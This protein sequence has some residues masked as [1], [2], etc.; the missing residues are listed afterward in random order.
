MQNK[1]FQTD[2]K[3]FYREIGKTKLW[4]KKHYLRNSIEKFWKEIWGEE[5][6]CNIST[7]WIGNAEK[8]NE[9]VNEQK[10]ENITVLELKAALTKSQKWKSPG[11]NKV[12]K[13]KSLSWS[14]VAF[15]SLLNGIMQNPE[16]NFWMDVQRNSILVKNNDTKDPKTIDQSLVFQQLTNF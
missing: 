16:R 10:W 11:V 13:C 5:K 2:S 4:W 7:S 12:P 15:L 3:K 8:E 1:I 9:K 6:A 14:N